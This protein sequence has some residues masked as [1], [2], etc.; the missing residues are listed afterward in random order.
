[1][2]IGTNVGGDTIVY[3]EGIWALGWWEWGG[4]TTAH[5]MVFPRK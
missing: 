1:M 4:D 2:E 5:D 3:G